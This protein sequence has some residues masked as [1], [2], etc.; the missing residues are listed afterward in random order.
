MDIP[1]NHPR[2]LSLKYRHRIVDGLKQGFVAD[3]GLI[4]HGRGEAYDYLLGEKT[5]DPALNAEKA[6]VAAMLL[7]ENPVISVNGN[8]AALVPGEIVE[9]AES[10]NAKIEI[11]LF[12][13]TLEREQL[14]EK[15]LKDNGA[16]RVYGVGDRDM[17]SIPGLSSQRKRA[18]KEASWSADTILVPLED[19]DRAEALVSTGKCTITIDLNPLSRTSKS[20]TIPIVDNIVRARPN[21]I[22]ISEKLRSWNAEKLMELHNSFNAQECLNSMVGIIRKGF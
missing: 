13:R 2:Y 8:S 4:A 21:M 20:A 10:L 7:S 12:Y 15:I 11:N 18:A 6:A 9:L 3:S 17:Q 19:G 5:C 14:I 22:H 1:Q 16:D